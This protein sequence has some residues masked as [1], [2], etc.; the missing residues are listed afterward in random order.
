MSFLGFGG[1]S[2]QIS[3]EAKLKAAEAELDM[4]TAMFNQLV[5]SCNSKCFD[6]TYSEGDLTKAESLCV[7]RCVAK[8]FEANVKV[9]ESMQ[10][11]GRSGQLGKNF[12]Q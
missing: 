12:G 2:P 4:V 6:K 9:G 5:E 3:S 10:K 11:L 7:D 8:Y 1:S